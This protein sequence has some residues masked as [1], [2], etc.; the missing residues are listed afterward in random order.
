MNDIDKGL[1][2]FSASCS[3]QRQL[4]DELEGIDEGKTFLEKEENEWQ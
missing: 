4:R 1:N 2:R 3:S